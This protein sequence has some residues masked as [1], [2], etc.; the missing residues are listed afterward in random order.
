[1]HW[2][3][4]ATYHTEREEEAG[5]SSV[6]ELV[7]FE[8]RAARAQPPVSRPSHDPNGAR[9]A[10]APGWRACGTRPHPMPGARSGLRTRAH[11]HKI[12]KLGVPGGDDAVNLSLNL[13][14]CLVGVGAVVLA[15]PCLPLPVL[16]HDELDHAAPGSPRLR[17][18][19][20]AGSE[21]AAA[22]R[23]APLPRPALPPAAFGRQK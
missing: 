12:G 1:M 20:P 8:L 7:L 23:R 5:V 15:E 19:G 17:W 21:H 3:G 11:L 4:A 14:L 18:C 2:P 9:G 10:A 13:G 22:R 16:Q 6:D